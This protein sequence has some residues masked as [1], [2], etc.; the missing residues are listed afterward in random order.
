MI[1]AGYDEAVLW[2]CTPLQLMARIQ[3]ASKRKKR[4]AAMALS[5]GAMAA[6]GDPRKVKDQLKKLEKD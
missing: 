4:D 2:N 3:F 1:G 6:R 5:L